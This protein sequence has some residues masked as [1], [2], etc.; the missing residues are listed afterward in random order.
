MSYTA[1]IFFATTAKLSAF[2]VSA[3]YDDDADEFIKLSMIQIQSP[4]L[5]DEIL[6]D[7]QQKMTQFP[8]L[9]KTAESKA[10][11]QDTVEKLTNFLNNPLNTGTEYQ[12]I[13]DYTM[14]ILKKD[15]LTDNMLLI[16]QDR[17]DNF[18][19]IDQT[20]EYLQL[21]SLIRSIDSLAIYVEA[22]IS[23]QVL[24]I[25]DSYLQHMIHSSFTLENVK[26]MIHELGCLRYQALR[27]PPS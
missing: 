23:D 12:E 20:P 2:I 5:T 24:L 27:E 1:D 7:M 25:T 6:L 13:V 19:P 8:R 10:I 17:I 21:S 18:T 15:D 16:A 4:D 11:Y 9:S 22:G 26:L 3:C 14:A